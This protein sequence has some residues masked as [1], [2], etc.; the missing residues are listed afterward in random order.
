MN[1]LICLFCLILLIFL[2]FYESSLVKVS[3]IFTGYWTF[4][5][6]MA[7]IYIKDIDYIVYLIIFIGIIFFNFG[8][9]STKYRINFF[10]NNKSTYEIDEKS[11]EISFFPIMFFLIFLSIK[12]INLIHS[13]VSFN[14]IR[15]KYMDEIL[16]NYI[17]IVIFKFFI[18]PIIFAYVVAFFSNVYASN[19]KIKK[20]F[21]AYSIILT[22]LE[23]F[24]LSDRIIMLVWIIGGALSYNKLKTKINKKKIKVLQRLSVVFILAIF[25]VLIMRQTDILRNTIIYLSGSLKFFSNS[26]TFNDYK[27]TYGVAS[28]Q[29]VFRPIMGIL[30]KIGI[31]WNL[32]DEADKFLLNN[33]YT[34][35]TVFKDGGNINYFTTSFAYFMKDFGLIGVM[36]F[37]FLW[38]RI[39]K[40]IEYDL[41]N[42]SDNA[43]IFFGNYIFVVYSIV[44][45]TMNSLLA[46]VSFAWG[47]IFFI[48]FFLKK[49]SVG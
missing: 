7:T 8:V 22:I 16:N 14:I 35:V 15:Y 33:Q 29:G 41:N 43:A 18:S 4:I 13:G 6:W 25:G 36:L 28:M 24:V 37:S 17:L 49:K 39:A 26:L 34:L 32:F 42:S 48:I 5:M 38:G 2:I 47:I 3:I 44:L 31:S 27:L 46:E 1:Y 10:Q 40:K 19:G 9:F 30:E 12:V 23:F 11:L 21:L 45:S 20:K